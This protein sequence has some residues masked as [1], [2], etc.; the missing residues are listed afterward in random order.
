MHRI[1]VGRVALIPATPEDITRIYQWL[2]LS[3]L[4]SSMLGPPDF[5]DNA[6]PSWEEFQKDYNP[7]FFT[8]D[9]PYHG[10]SFIIDFENEAVGHINYNEFNPGTP[11][12]LDIWLSASRHC[13]KGLGTAAIKLLC[14]YLHTTLGC[15]EFIIAPSARNTR[16]IKAYQKAGFSITDNVPK[17]FTPDYTDTVVL[18]KIYT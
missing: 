4:T 1:S 9:D 14:D 18:K 13:N 6:I 11:V 5:S 10:R 7:M 17:A 15:Q 3:D 2:A 16:A 12:E 8:D